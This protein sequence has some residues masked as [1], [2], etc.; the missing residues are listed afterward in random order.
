MRR[1]SVSR[2]KNTIQ[3]VLVAVTLLLAVGT[4]ASAR[5]V[6]GRARAAQISETESYRMMPTTSL[7]RWLMKRFSRYAM[8]A[9]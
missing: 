1:L 2:L 5:T 4:P 8:A 7:W 3:V 6:A 9:N